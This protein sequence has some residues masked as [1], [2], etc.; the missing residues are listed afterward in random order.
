[1]RAAIKYPELD[2]SQ[3]SQI[4]W[5]FLNFVREKSEGGQVSLDHSVF[6]EENIK[7][8]AMK[9]FNGPCSHTTLCFILQEALIW[10]VSG[11][12]IKNVVRTA[13]A[14]SISS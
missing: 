10:T 1:M 9:P 11:R 13:Q 6:E 14:L 12:V 5:Q 7:E 2:I 4:W 3:R 8:L